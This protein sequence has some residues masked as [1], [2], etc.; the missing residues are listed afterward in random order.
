MLNIALVGTWHVHFDQYANEI[1]N[2]KE[3][4]IMGVWDPDLEK[5]E[6][7]AKNFG[8][9][10]YNNLDDALTNK[11]VD[12]IVIC[13]ATN[14]HTDIILKA[15]ENKKHIF[16]EKVLC[17][18]TEDAEKIVKSVK[19]NNTKFCISYPWR[20]R[21]DYL[22]VKDAL[23]QNLIGDVTY[24]RMRNAHNGASAGW[25]P[26]HFFDPV[27]CGGG[28]MMD[29]GAH[30]MYLI[31]WLL[32]KPKA[33][34]ST[35]TNMTGKEVEDNA[36]SILEYENGAIAVSETGFVSSHNPF[37]LEISGTNGTIYAGGH[38]NE[39]V[40]NIGEGWVN[41]TLPEPTATPT[42]LWVDGITKNEIIP[43]DVDAAYDLTVLMEH[44]YLSHQKGIKVYL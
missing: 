4:A 43:F 21:S 41:P 35:F 2:N 27:E 11:E 10:A 26:P 40:Y 12:G 38:T 34:S 7:A 15:C 36:V 44:A 31:S 1:K 37:T 14:Q 24:M 3:C 29:L 5:A 28:A 32:G 18:T 33:I 23:S 17:F 9:F 30:S 39:C 22:W 16:T 19:E 42:T 25:L 13:T 20:T 8:T 6:M